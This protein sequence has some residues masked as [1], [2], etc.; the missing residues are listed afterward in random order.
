MQQ[1]KVHLA[2]SI[3][4]CRTRTCY[5]HRPTRSFSTSSN[6]KNQLKLDTK[7]VSRSSESPIIINSNR[8]QASIRHR[9]EEAQSD[10]NV[11]RILELCQELKQ[12]GRPSQDELKLAYRHLISILA[13]YGLWTQLYATVNEL[14]ELIELKDRD[15]L[16]WA[17]IIEGF[18]KCDR[19]TDVIYSLIIST[20]INIGPHTITA[21]FRAAI[22]ESN[23]SQSILLLQVA[24]ASELLPQIPK[25]LLIQLA[26]SLAEHGQLNL[27]VDLLHSFVVP[28]KETDHPDCVGGLT[29]LLRTCVN[30]SDPQST[31][32]CYSYLTKNHPDMIENLLDD[33]LMIELLSLSSRHIMPDLALN[34]LSQLVRTRRKLEMTH[35]FP[36]IIALCRAGG[37]MSEV[38]EI[39]VRVGKELAIGTEE[40]ELVAFNLMVGH[41]GGLSEYR[42]LIQSNAQ[43][44]I[45]DGQQDEKREEILNGLNK[46]KQLCRDLLIKRSNNDQHER[47]SIISHSLVN[48]LIQAD[49][50]LHRPLESLAT[51]KT[52]FSNPQNHSTC[53]IFQPD[54]HTLSLLKNAAEQASSDHRSLQTEILS[55]IDDLQ[56]EISC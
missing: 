22:L 20:G 24:T 19:S 3:R 56:K 50:E 1:V 54:Q 26:G 23:L 13:H 6:P 7:T 5:E 42:K 2:S 53:F 34:V 36:T 25:T 47:A 14:M 33:G 35:L 49:L 21:L 48:S 52:Y 43:E 18:I 16:L 45:P 8:S 27:A 17:T 10:K 15:D 38:I 55:I 39:L 12:A 4:K 40:N 44:E 31:L 30:R 46:S 11:V 29:R 41:L 9:F 51:F 28:I 37:R 32:Y